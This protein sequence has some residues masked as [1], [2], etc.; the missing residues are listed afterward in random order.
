MIAA[1]ITSYAIDDY[2]SSSPYLTGKI[3]FQEGGERDACFFIIKESEADLA[4]K[5]FVQTA[6][7]ADDPGILKPYFLTYYELKKIWILC[8]DKFDSLLSEDV[9][10]I[11]LTE[12]NMGDSIRYVC[13]WIFLF[14]FSHAL[15]IFL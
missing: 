1:R 6:K 8:Y 7:M 11:V 4:K 15:P 13:I 10:Q 3:K 9:S 5:I 12:K 2:K 14:S